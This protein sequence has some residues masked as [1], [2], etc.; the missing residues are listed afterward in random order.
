MN[1]FRIDRANQNPA[2]MDLL[3]QILA[4]QHMF[5]EASLS[6][7]SKRDNQ[8]LAELTKRFEAG[9]EVYRKQLWEYVLENFGRLDVD[10]LIE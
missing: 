10:D 1:K 9:C 6:D 8:D 3:I 5:I 2:V 7:W 4:N